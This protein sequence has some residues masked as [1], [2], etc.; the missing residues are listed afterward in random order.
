MGKSVE[1]LGLAAFN[2]FLALILAATF[3]SGGGKEGKSARLD[4]LTEDHV[5]GFIKEVN[6]ITSGARTDMDSFKVSKYFMDH[7]AET[8]KFIN[9]VS[10]EMPQANGQEKTLEM[11]K[12]DFISHILQGMKQGEGEAPAQGQSS[13]SIENIDIADN[14]KIAHI[15]TTSQE[16]GVMPMD[17][18]S[19]EATMVPIVGVSYC[20][21]TVVLE[22][23]SIQM[24]NAKCTTTVNYADQ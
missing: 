7:I 10:Y 18:G 8:G 2:I 1:L 19:G 17:D 6:E 12:M 5:S 16:R 3:L 20:E 24:Q 21:Q 15:V 9:T 14:G 23:K 4:S 11:G 22:S 13:V